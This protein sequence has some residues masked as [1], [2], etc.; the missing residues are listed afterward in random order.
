MVNGVTENIM[1]TTHG[2]RKKQ[3]KWARVNDQVVLAYFEGTGENERLVGYTPFEDLVS[4]ATS[5]A[6][7]EYHLDF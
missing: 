5:G 2:R 7:P 6:L 1:Y 4:I 3:G